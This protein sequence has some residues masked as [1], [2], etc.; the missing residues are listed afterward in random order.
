[1][2]CRQSKS[3]P[4]IYP[5]QPHECDHLSTNAPLPRDALEA[6][7]VTQKLDLATPHPTEAA[8]CDGDLPV[9]AAPD[10]TSSG[11]PQL[12]KEEPSGE[13]AS[14]QANTPLQR[15]PRWNP[16]DAEPLSCTCSDSRS[17]EPAAPTRRFFRAVSPSSAPC[18][19]PQ[20][21]QRPQHQLSSPSSLSNRTNLYFSQRRNLKSD[22][23]TA[24]CEPHHGRPQ[25]RALPIP[26]SH[27]LDSAQMM[28]ARPLPAYGSPNHNPTSFNSAQDLSAVAGSPIHC[29]SP[30]EVSPFAHHRQSGAR[31]NE[32]GAAVAAHSPML[33]ACH[34]FRTAAPV[35]NERGT[36]TSASVPRAAPAMHFSDFLAR[37]SLRTHHGQRSGDATPRNSTCKDKILPASAAN[38]TISPTRWSSTNT[39][40]E[41]SCATSYAGGSCSQ[42]FGPQ[43]P[44]S[45]IES[46]HSA[47]PNSADSSSF[48][49]SI[50]STSFLGQGPTRVNASPLP[51]TEQIFSAWQRSSSSVMPFDGVKLPPPQDDVLSN[52]VSASILMPHRDSSRSSAEI[53]LGNNSFTSARL[54][55]ASRETEVSCE[56]ETV[57]E[58]VARMQATKRRSEGDVDGTCAAEST[59]IRTLLTGSSSGYGGEAARTAS[60]GTHAKCGSAGRIS[61]SL[62]VPPPPPLRVG[63]EKGGATRLLRPRPSLD[64]TSDAPLVALTPSPQSTL[65]RISSSIVISPSASLNDRDVTSAGSNRPNSSCRRRDV[66]ASVEA[67]LAS[68]SSSSA[69]APPAASR[70]KRR[71]MAVN[72]LISPQ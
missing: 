37:G 36:S 47:A 17:S 52:A 55:M 34:R 57:V 15:L 21:R 54:R 23:I 45:S 26:D 29:T 38:L 42:P 28:C 49:S 12:I 27:Q 22:H 53:T 14:Q 16:H 33:P 41:F 30:L 19:P 35:T 11:T 46:A 64:T 63:S 6:V 13:S 24:L 25:L 18:T 9:A 43:P 60:R 39:P 69:P 68:I 10:S 31:R 62:S 65:S 7:P 61:A 1:M 8:P 2:G 5:A 44:C 67:A 50:S 3:A 70:R 51:L 66:K 59:D 56:V 32:N 71:D 72:F 40:N 20:Q 58:F 48:A 4:E